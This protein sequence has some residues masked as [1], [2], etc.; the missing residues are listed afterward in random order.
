MPDDV[1]IITK[2]DVA[3]R[4]VEESMALAEQGG[5]RAVGAAL[6]EELATLRR[7]REEALEALVKGA[8]EL[9]APLRVRR[10]IALKK[11]GA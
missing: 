7:I 6:A 3:V 9:D 11:P 1:N 8:T 10:P 5:L 4:A 2:L